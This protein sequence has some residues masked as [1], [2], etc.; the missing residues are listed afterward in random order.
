MN[1]GRMG[2]MLALA[3]SATSPQAATPARDGQHDFDWEIGRWTTSVRVL[4]NPLSGEAPK[5]AEYRGES[6]IKPLVVGLTASPERIVQ[7][8]QNRLLG[9]KAHR[10]GDQYID[11]EAVA[12]EVAFS[13]RLC[14]RHN[15][16]LIDVSRRSIE[17]TAAAVIAL[18]AERRRQPAV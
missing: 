6:L 2:W 7:I 17:E 13:R 4:Q 14:G 12:D 5:W 15:W 16:P 3:V 9:L 1:V 10:D 11:R 8:R 18:L